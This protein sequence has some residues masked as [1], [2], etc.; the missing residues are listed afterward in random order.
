MVLEIFVDVDNMHEEIDILVDCKYKIHNY[1]CTFSVLCKCHPNLL[2]YSSWTKYTEEN[3][4][5]L[6]IFFRIFKF[7]PVF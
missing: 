2:G 5:M 6:D 3:T 7:V 4:N 1:N